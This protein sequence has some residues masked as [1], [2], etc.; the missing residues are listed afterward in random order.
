[1]ST[2]A[3]PLVIFTDR[4]D[5]DP[6]PA[7]DL[8]EANGF[9]SAVLDL[10]NDPL[11]PED[12]RRAVAAI[13]GYARIGDAVLQQLPDLR[14]LCTSSVGTDMVDEAAAARHGVEVVGLAGASTREVAT[15]TLA[16]A[17]AAVRELPA[18]TAVARDGGW[19]THFDRIPR[20]TEDLVFGLLGFGRIAQATA[21]LARP[22]FGR[23]IAHDPFQSAPGAEHVG[24]DDLLARADVLSLHVPLTEANRGIVSADAIGRLPAG[25]VIVNTSRGELVDDAAVLAALESGRVSAYAADVLAGEPPQAA[26]P[27]RRHPRAIVTPH[28]AFL[29]DRSLERYLL[30][31]AR[32]ILDRLGPARPVA[33]GT[34]TAMEATS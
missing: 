23:I 21:E 26:D 28:I 5:L 20:A 32:T 12:A 3:R 34:I 15:H 4:A 29:S 9:D 6:V 13:V 18:A 7:I 17:L 25:S 2:A 1:M 19:T 27:L 24:F 31:P 11:V 14:V 16:L 10:A 22:V 8:L 30:S 33:T